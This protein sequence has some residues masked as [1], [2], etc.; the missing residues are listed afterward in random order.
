MLS[1]GPVNIET[2]IKEGAGLCDGECC[3]KRLWDRA[4]GSIELLDPLRCVTVL[5]SKCLWLYQ[6]P[7]TCLTV[8]VQGC[9]ETVLFQ[10][11][12]SSLISLC[13]FDV[14]VPIYDLIITTENVNFTRLARPGTRK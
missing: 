10:V 7:F 11:V 9:M 5:T 12:V 3:W 6:C 13:S 14:N 2:S 4:F 1:E 8:P